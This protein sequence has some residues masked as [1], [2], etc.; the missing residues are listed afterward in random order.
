[1]EWLPIDAAPKDGRPKWV[2]GYFN[3]DFLRCCWAYWDSTYEG[4][5]EA[6]L[7]GPRLTPAEYCPD[8]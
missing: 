4:W 2:R 1:M 7:D 5:Y 6:R 3:R 8:P